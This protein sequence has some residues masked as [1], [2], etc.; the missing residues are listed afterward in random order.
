MRATDFAAIRPHLQGAI[1][2][3][4]YYL[5]RLEAEE[6]AEREA[7]DLYELM[8]AGKTPPEVQG[9]G[10][11]VQLT[12][13]QEAALRWQT[14]SGEPLSKEQRE[15]VLAALPSG[16]PMSDEEWAAFQYGL[17][18]GWQ[19]S[20]RLVA[21]R[22]R[23]AGETL[24]AAEIDG[25]LQR[26]PDKP[27]EAADFAGYRDAMRREAEYVK[28]ILATCLAG[29]MAQADKGSTGND[30]PQSRSGKLKPSELASKH[31]VAQRA[32][33]ARLERWRYEHDA[34]YVEVSNA[35]RNEPKYLYDEASVMPVIEALK[36]KSVAQKRATDVQQ[37]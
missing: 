37:K 28:T 11:P 13:E 34:G 21:V 16:T 36:A 27:W 35:A 14:P 20:S 4:A 22:M 30:P 23:N 24:A 18:G 31:G 3:I 17:R 15:A 12:A 19:E 29:A 1:E 10:R 32:L 7:C 25:A 33:E 8:I 5:N 6:K 9:R 2:D 26:L